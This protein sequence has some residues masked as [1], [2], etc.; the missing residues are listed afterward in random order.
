M[1]EGNNLL[2][3]PDLT[4]WT[5]APAGEGAYDVEMRRNWW[6]TADVALIREHIFDRLWLE[7]ND[8]Q[9]TE[10]MGTV[11]IEPV[12]TQPNGIGFIRGRV[13]DRSSGQPIRAATV[14]VN[15]HTLYSSAGGDFFTSA[16]QGVAHLT[17][18][19]P[20]YVPANRDAHVCAGLLAD[21]TVELERDSEGARPTQRPVQ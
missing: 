9:N 2:A 20:G 17:V 10:E 19:S 18:T 1:V 4:F 21:V 16:P 3:R 13:L 7:E 5:S 15:G 12:L 11:W 8:P 6:G 14:T